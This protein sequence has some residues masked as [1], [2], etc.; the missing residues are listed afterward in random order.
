MSSFDKMIRGMRNINKLVLSTE[1]CYNCE[2]KSIKTIELV[3]QNHLL[4]EGSIILDVVLCE[5]C[6]TRIMKPVID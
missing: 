6:F 5:S 3:I 4:S 2:K 1:Y